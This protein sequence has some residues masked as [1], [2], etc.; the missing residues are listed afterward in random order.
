VIARQ[1]DE[2]QQMSSSVTTS[3]APPQHSES[4]DI[5]KEVLKEYLDIIE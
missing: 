5:P 4:G 1:S 3:L 2:Q